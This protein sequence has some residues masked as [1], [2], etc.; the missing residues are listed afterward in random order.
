MSDGS[1]D[2][3]ESQ[4]E[5]YNGLR[6]FA[7]SVLARLY[8]R[9]LS[10]ISAYD[11]EDETAR[12][13]VAVLSHCVRE[14]INA[15]PDYLDNGA[16]SSSRARADAALSSL[17]ACLL[18]GQPMSLHQVGEQPYGVVSADILDA[19]VDYREC[20]IK[21]LQRSDERDSLAVLG[22]V[23]PQNPAV[24]A[25]RKARTFFVGLAHIPRDKAK[26]GNLPSSHDVKRHFALIENALAYR[27]GF[28]FDAKARVAGALLNTYSSKLR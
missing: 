11:S 1:V 18:S 9:C 14:L 13:D 20:L 5:I 26:L 6:E 15:L 27:L 21:G 12:I 25:W 2:M 7:D 3:S 10:L 28:F 8:K 23:E 19:L 4:L 22:K 24:R 16:S 17:R